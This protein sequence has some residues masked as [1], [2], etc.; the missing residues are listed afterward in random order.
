[1]IVILLN[2]NNLVWTE[3][4]HCEQKPKVTMERNSVGD[5]VSSNVRFDVYVTYSEKDFDWVKEVF[6][7][8]PT[9]KEN[10][11][12]MEKEFGFKFIE[13]QKRD[14]TS[15]SYKIMRLTDAMERSRRLIVIISR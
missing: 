9:A 11:F 8:D 7:Y 10:H 6:E 2:L 1:M 13:P 15:G 4:I 12:G 14:V 3:F 5:F